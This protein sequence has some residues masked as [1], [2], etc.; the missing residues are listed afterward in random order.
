MERVKRPKQSQ[1]ELTT[2]ASLLLQYKKMLI[3]EKYN[4]IY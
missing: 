3:H 4:F 2:L 1:A